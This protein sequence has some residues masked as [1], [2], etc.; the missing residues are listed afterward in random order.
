MLLIILEVNDGE[1]FLTRSWLKAFMDS[2]EQDSTKKGIQESL[3][4]K[5]DQS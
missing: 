4:R 5:N 3:M 1:V 2:T